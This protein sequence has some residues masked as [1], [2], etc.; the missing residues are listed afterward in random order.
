MIGPH[1]GKE[2]ELMLAGEKPLAAFGDIIPPDGEISEEIIPEQKF[3]PYVK[4]GAIKR[5]AADISYK[6]SKEMVRVICFTLPGEEWRAQFMI[7]Y[8]AAF[9]SD[10]IPYDP[11]QE[12]IIGE[13]LGYSTEDIAHFITNLEKRRA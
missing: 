2:L 3:A 12:Y 7:W 6:N 4:A 10:R 1:E 5:F 13:L 8:K 9:Y 11:S